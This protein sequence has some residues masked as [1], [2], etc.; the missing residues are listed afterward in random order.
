MLRCLL[1]FL[2]T[3]YY[4]IIEGKT[5]SDLLKVNLKPIPFDQCKHGYSKSEN[6]KV[7]FGID[8][9]SML[10]A[11]DFEDGINDTCTV[12]KIIG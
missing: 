6:S 4:L 8:E 7:N 3:W 9:K 1:G 10:C 12:R 5:S 11:G 2:F